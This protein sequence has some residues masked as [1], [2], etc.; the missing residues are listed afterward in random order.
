MKKV[1]KLICPDCKAKFAIKQKVEIG[2]ILEC[3]ECATEVE[4]LSVK[5]LKYG[6]LIEEK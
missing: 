4:I 5:P 3:P 6:E 1:I 2:D